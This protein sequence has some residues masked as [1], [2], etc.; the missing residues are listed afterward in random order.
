MATG[1]FDGKIRIWN[2][3]S[4]HC[5]VTLAGQEHTGPIKTI[6]F[7]PSSKFIL[8]ASLDGTVRAWDLLRYRNS[9]L[10]PLQIL[11]NFWL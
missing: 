5:F 6:K 8:S 9:A 4:G 10:L 3:H 1:A 11:F 2:V 7:A